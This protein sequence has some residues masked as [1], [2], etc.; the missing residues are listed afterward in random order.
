MK[1]TLLTINPMIVEG[2]RF[3]TMRRLVRLLDE[4]C[5]L[6][7]APVNG[8]DFK[9]GRVTVYKRNADGSFLKL[10]QQTP[11]ADLWIVYSDGFDRNHSSFG[12]RLRRDYL[13]AQLDFHQEQ[14]RVGNVA[15]VIN[16]PAAE[17]RTLKSWMATLD[18]KASSVIPTHVFSTIAEVYDFQRA[19][20]A[21]V[22]KL[23]WGGA[24]VGVERL[25]DE[26]DVR[27]FQVRLAEQ[28][29]RDLSDFCFQPYCRGDEKRFWFVGG[30][31]QA[32]RIIHGRETPW[33][34][35]ADDFWV[36]TYGPDSSGNFKRD[37][38]AAERLC[39]LSGI[40]IGAVDFIGSRINEV[41]GGGTV[42]TTYDHNKMI[43]DNRPA[44]LAY[45]RAVLNSL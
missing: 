29:D 21:I 35:D 24:G 6:L 42:L 36:S 5:D 17:T 23:S 18:F 3:S 28:A 11:R 37:L 13:Q 27:A 43:I 38:A 8:Y 7:L 34:D 12:F 9:R 40:S 19:R 10:G 33:S 15:C 25:L 45:V 22:A 2:N 1:K 41:N 39:D 20:G 26:A 30:R 4:E 31:F 44:F 32:A 14:L 16:S